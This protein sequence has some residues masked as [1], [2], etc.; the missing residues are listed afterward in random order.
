MLYITIIL[1]YILGCA[2]YCIA[3][4]DRIGKHE[5]TLHTDGIY[6]DIVGKADIVVKSFFWPLMLPFIVLAI[7]LRIVDK[8]K[9]TKAM[10]KLNQFFA[11]IASV[12]KDKLLHALCGMLFALGMY[13]IFNLFGCSHAH[14]Y[15][16]FSAVLIGLAKEIYDKFINHERF[17]CYDWLAT[18]LGGMAVAMLTI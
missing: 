16:F 5:Y 7:I 11:W 4:C 18:V 8:L 12:P 10:N 9:K 14:L 6:E 2:I 1:V 17:D 3:M 15:T 13:R